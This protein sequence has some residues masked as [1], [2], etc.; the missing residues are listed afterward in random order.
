MY[1][2]TSEQSFKNCRNWITSM[3]ECASDECVL[4]I[5]G[6]K[7]DLCENEDCRVV[8]YKDGAKLADV[9]FLIRN[10]IHLLFINKIV[11]K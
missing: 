10:S 6:N 4:T 1:D 11:L 9:N 5:I 2:I 7:I 3:R 8:K